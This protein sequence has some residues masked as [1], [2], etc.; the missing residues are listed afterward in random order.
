MK[1]L[2]TTHVFLPEHFGG[3]ENL[4]LGVALALKHRGHDVTVVTGYPAPE[5]R[6]EAEQFDE[7]E[8]QSIR[9]VRFKHARIVGGSVTRVMRNDYDNPLFEARFRRLLDEV[10]PDIVH[11]HHL[12][13]LSIRAIDACKE[14]SIP[15]FLTATDFWYVCPVH[16]LLLPDGSMCNGPDGAAANCLKHVSSISQPKAVAGA[17]AAVPNMVLAGVMS[18]LKKSQTEFSGSVGNAQAL[19][20]R[21]ETIAQRLPFVRRIFVA[22]NHARKML[23]GAGVKDTKFRV[24]PFGIKNYGYVRRVRERTDKKLVLGF[25]GSFLRHKGLHVLLDAVRLLPADIDVLIKVYGKSPVGESD[26]V[27][28]IHARAQGQDRVEFCGTFETAKIPSVL[29]GIDALV[30]PSMW[31]ENMPLVSL[32]AQAAGCPLIVSDIGGLSDIVTHGKNGLVFEA[33]SASGLSHAITTL[34]EDRELLKRLSSAAI[35]PLDIDQYVDELELEYQ[36]CVGV[37]N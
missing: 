2:L 27:K 14:R 31:H 15:A 16:T 35:H 29:D 12:E 19:V 30:I 7:Y 3:T 34:Y 36:Q 23:E 17:V 33:G 24:L 4:V 1:I 6:S 28:D 25:I 5:L 9:V 8:Y 22:S 37:V 26:Y 13:R 11:F 20:R 10:K 21:R 18:C 32:S